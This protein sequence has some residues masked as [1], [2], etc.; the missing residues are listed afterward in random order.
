MVNITTYVR[1]GG[2][3]EFFVGNMEKE[4]TSFRAE[5]SNKDSGIKANASNGSESADNQASKEGKKWP[6]NK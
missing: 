6:I 4:S 5:K 2:G 1:W 3:G